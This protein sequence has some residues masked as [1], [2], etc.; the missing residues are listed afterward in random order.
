MDI[1]FSRDLMGCNSCFGCTNLRNKQYYIFNKKYSKEDY[2][3]MIVSFNLGSFRSLSAVKQ[4]T[5][6]I[7]DKSIRKFIEGRYNV[8]VSGEYINN[9]KNVL[10]SY[11]IIQGEDSKYIQCFF[12]PSFK[13]CYDCTEWGENSELCYECSSVGADCYDIKFSYRC[14]KGCQNCEYSFLCYGCS[15]I[16]GCSSLRNKQYCI[17]NKQYSKEDYFALK[18]KIIKQMNDVPFTDEKGIVYRYGEFLP[19]ELSPFPYNDSQAQDYFPL[20][21]EKALKQG[22][23]WSDNEERKYTV[24]IKKENIPDDIKEVEKD[25]IGKVIECAHKGKCNEQCTEAFKIIEPE[26]QFYKRMNLPLPRL[27]HNCRHYERIKM[28]NPIRLYRRKCMNKGCQNEFETSYSPNRPEIIYCEKC[29][30]QEVY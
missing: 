8:N 20:E 16:F 19:P 26:L 10:S 23:E 1:Y 13:S 12:T 29:Y 18:E 24:D 17:L 5:D 9:S 3:K 15:N 2:E 7:I 30:Q 22:Y 27:C 4:K 11:Y 25:I 28:R 21:K 6:E 14:S